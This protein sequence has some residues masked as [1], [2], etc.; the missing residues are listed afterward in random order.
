MEAT[1]EN[2]IVIATYLLTKPDNFTS[3][4]VFCFIVEKYDTFLIQSFKRIVA[5]IVGT[6]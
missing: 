3:Y 6:S 4:I 1:Q 2:K 5:L